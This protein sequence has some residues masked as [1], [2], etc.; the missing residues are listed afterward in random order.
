M[1]WGGWREGVYWPRVVRVGRDSDLLRPLRYTLV[2]T[3][4]QIVQ[5]RPKLDIERYDYLIFEHIS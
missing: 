1:E 5:M 3:D 4:L 2:L